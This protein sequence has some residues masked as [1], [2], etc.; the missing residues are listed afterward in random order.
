MMSRLSLSAIV[1]GI[2]FAFVVI[3]IPAILRDSPPQVVVQMPQDAEPLSQLPPNT[4]VVAGD[5]AVLWWTVYS[6]TLQDLSNSDWAR[7]AADAAVDKVY[8]PLPKAP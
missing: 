4:K 7:F 6:R 1:A 8:G 2:A 3:I 5:R